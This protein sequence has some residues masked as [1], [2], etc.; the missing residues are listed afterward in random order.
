MKNKFFPLAEIKDGYLLK[1]LDDDGSVY[2]M[3]V[4]HNL[5]EDLGC[6][7]RKC[8]NYWDLS[9]FNSELIYDDSRI[10]AIYG[11]A[12]NSCLFD[13]DAYGRELLWER[14]EKPEPKEMTVAEVCKALGYEVK[15]V[16]D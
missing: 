10:I 4:A 15:I 14:D 7:S 1:I 2:F 9:S 8:D 11:R 3:Q 12:T 16:K 5:R 6:C 13:F